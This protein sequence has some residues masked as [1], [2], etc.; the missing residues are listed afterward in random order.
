MPK[1][2]PRLIPTGTC[3][4]GCGTEVGL[5]SFFSQGHDKVAE[6]ALLAARYDNS[7]ARL[8]AHHGFGPENGVRE[9]A[10]ESGYWEACPEASC[11]YLGT[12][13]SIRL[14]RKKTQH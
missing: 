2:E 4:C 1:S 8:I 6:A 12:P 7:V 5:G 11:G 3:W 10:V 14:H 13:A 9:A